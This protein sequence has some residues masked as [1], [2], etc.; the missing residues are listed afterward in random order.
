[1]LEPQMPPICIT[2]SIELDSQ[3]PET[4]AKRMQMLTLPMLMR[5]AMPGTPVSLS[6]PCEW[7]LLARDDPPTARFED[8]ARLF[9]ISVTMHVNGQYSPVATRNRKKYESPEYLG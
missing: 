9:A 1:M 4:R 7:G 6:T 8:G 3:A 5:R 2:V